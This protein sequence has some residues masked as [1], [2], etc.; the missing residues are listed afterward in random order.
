[1]NVDWFTVIAQ[2]F[3]F[4][5][6]VGL[7]KRFLYKPIVEA[8]DQREE[9]I[10]Q[11]IAE[12]QKREREATE[13]AKSFRERREEIE[14]KR[15]ETLGRAAQE[16]AEKRRQLIEQARREVDAMESHWKEMLQKERDAFLDDLRRRAG[17]Q[18]C[19]VTGRILRDL[20]D[21]RLQE[22]LVEVF[23]HRFRE[24][25]RDARARIMEAAEGDDGGLTVRT[26]F[27]LGD[28]LQERIEGSLRE[29]LA[30]G[31]EIQFATD[32]ELIC[33]IELRAAGRKIGWNVGDYLDGLRESLARALDEEVGDTDGG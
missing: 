12:A 1:M 2:V 31:A 9:R 5:I 28:D 19:D 23:L 32:E 7:L 26:A 16:A 18:I 3:N 29:L 4:L 17:R 33:G 15:Q 25:D 30:D 8:M 27:D 14:S 11:Q 24:Q 13:E 20:A 10:A 21:T 6:L 22:H